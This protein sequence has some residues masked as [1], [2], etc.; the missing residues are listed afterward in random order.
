MKTISSQLKEHLQQDSTTLATCW[1]VTRLD[2]LIFGF[3]DCSHDL[4][5]NDIVYYASTGQNSSNIKTTSKLDVDNLE[6]SANL[7]GIP[8]SYVD[9]IDSPFLTELDIK[10][11]LWDL[12]KI[13]IFIVNYE[14]LTMGSLIMRKGTIG[15]VKTG[16]SQF[17]AEL[18]GITQYLQQFIGRLFTPSCTANLGDSKCGVNMTPYTFNGSVT[19]V[20]NNHSWVDG[21]L[22]QTTSTVQKSI[23]NIAAGSTTYIQCNSHGFTAGT[24][25]TFSGISGSMNYLNGH[26]ANVG[27][28]D[29]NNFSVS[30][31]SSLFLDIIPGTSP[32]EYK[33]TSY[34]NGFVA[35]F[36]GSTWDTGGGTYI[37]GGVI[38]L[39]VISE[40]FQGGLI[41]WTSGLNDKLEM[42][43]KNYYPGYV[44]L[45]QQMPYNIQNGDTYI[46]KAGCDKVDSTCNN[47]YNNIINFRG[48]NLVPGNDKL[49]S[50]Q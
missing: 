3:T 19:A 10:A 44:F 6:V 27:Y 18:R 46:I 13:E 32:V 14:D 33:N 43:I 4:I 20:I 5:I 45:A 42:E 17:T 25:I 50:G 16:R 47:R 12:A 48:F 40:Y 28:I 1:K 9:V 29:L 34:S 39:S 15:E 35:T 7:G 21:S 41:T 30:I 8:I 49:M 23:Q 26:T 36:S 37:G 31:D 11:G 38:T 24:E 2:N 22:T